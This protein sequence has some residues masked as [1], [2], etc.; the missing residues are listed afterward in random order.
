MVI[1]RKYKIY[2]SWPLA[3]RNKFNIFLVITITTRDIFQY[4]LTAIEDSPS[5]T[6]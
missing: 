4:F 5:I 1:T 3:T 2:Y 6:R